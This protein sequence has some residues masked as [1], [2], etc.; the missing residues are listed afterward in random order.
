MTELASVNGTRIAY[1]IDGPDGAPW[2]TMSH[3]LSANGSM[4]DPQMPA[5][6]DAYRVLRFDTRGHGGSDAPAGE[7]TLDMLADD[8]IALWDDL[9]IETTH[10]CGLSMGGMIGQTLALKAPDRLRTL[11]LCDTASGYPAE[12]RAQWGERIAAARANGMAAS[13]DATIDRWFSPGFV[14]R[15]PATID[16]VRAMI[17]ATPV[18]GY[19]GCGAAI[20]QLT[21]TERL[22]EIEVPTLVIVGEDDPGTPVAMSETIRDG[23]AGAELVVLPV[24]RHLSNMEDVAGFN[25]ALRSFLDKH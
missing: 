23:I 22:G 20:A 1:T 10:Y 12:A 13:I 9:G 19:C 2:L 6:T 4:W 16:K 8:A 21:L 5:L 7:Y 24:A 25:A 3:S 14:K 15:D 11:V 18:N 17:A